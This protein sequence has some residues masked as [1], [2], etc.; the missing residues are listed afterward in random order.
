MLYD[1]SIS[2]LFLCL[3]T[4][5]LHPG[6]TVHSAVFASSSMYTICNSMYTICNSMYTIVL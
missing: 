3:H 2:I 4:E 1:V 6:G 5:C